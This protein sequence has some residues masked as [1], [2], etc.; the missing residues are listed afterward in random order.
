MIFIAGLLM[1][2]GCCHRNCG[3]DI[4]VRI[5]WDA[6]TYQEVTE[7]VIGN[8]GYVEKNLYYPRA[9]RISDGAILFTF[10]NHH[11]GWDIYAAR[12]EDDAAT[13]QDAFCVAH[14]YDT[15]YMTSDGR[16]VPDRIVYVNPDFTQLQDG[17]IILAFQWRFSGGYGDLPKTNENCG[18]MI[19]F[20]EDYGRTWC[21]PRE[22]YR[23][24]CWEPAFLQLPSGE[25][26]MYIT[27]SQDIKDRT[28]FPR[29]I[30]IRSF[31]GG[32][33]WQGKECCGI[34]DNEAI[35]RSYDDRF[36]YDGMPTGVLLDDN[37]GILV[38]LESW[39]GRYVVD[40]TPIVVKTTMEE[41]WRI[42]QQKIL[43]EGGPDFPM[44]KEVNRDFQGYGPYGSKLPSGEV[45][46]LSNGTY[47]GVQ[48]IW[49]FVGD[50][51]GDN[52]HHA[53]AAFT[54]NEY[55]GS[56]DYIGDDKLLATATFKYKDEAG[57]DRGMV[58]MICGR[59]NRALEIC[60]GGLEMAA[61]SAFDKSDLNWWFLGKDDLSSMYAGFGYTADALELGAYI[62]DN[63][64]ASF[65][66][67]NSDAAAILFARKGKM[68]EMVVNAA[69]RYVV[70]EDVRWSW[71]K[72]AEGTTSDLTV[73]GSINNDRDVDAGF[74]A[75]VCVPWSLIGGK[76]CRGEELRVHL[77]RFWKADSKEKPLSK[78]EDLQGENS[79]YP[80]EWLRVTLK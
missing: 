11:Y 29:T 54:D 57:V 42:D 37:A 53:T 73:D 66:P 75:K 20:S 60:R 49:T 23:G 58:R 74:C 33:T 30:V 59:V 6:S 78:V 18:I 2:A 77:R 38:P 32:A 55:W 35:S 4:D 46:V 10:S 28:S 25:I 41:N 1:L 48:G 15:T 17:R 65:T 44:K 34:Y 50:K 72:I 64:I 13:W 22:V 16:L 51:T 24:R 14:S 5:S 26:Q 3:D 61:P 27:S 70:Y 47:K 39:H 43:D 31:D 21:A 12:S 68:Y 9:K 40:Q 8:L 45:L 67:E 63:K 19:S 80:F 7:A 56:I 69:G 52:F 76:P 71:H 79:D 62:F 36:C